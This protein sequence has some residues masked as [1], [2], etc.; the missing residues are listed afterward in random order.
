MDWQLYLDKTLR[1]TD[2]CLASMMLFLVKYNEL[3]DRMLE[4]AH[5]EEEF[6][7]EC[8]IIIV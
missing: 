6:S 2:C 1:N 4:K 5:D 8:I 3:S 7:C